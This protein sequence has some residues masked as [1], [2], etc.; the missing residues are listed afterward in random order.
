[1]STDWLG[2]FDVSLDEIRWVVNRACR[3]GWRQYAD[4][5]FGEVLLK[6][7]RKHGADPECFKTKEDLL[8][9][10]YV[11][12]RNE[13][14]HM[15]REAGRLKFGDPRLLSEKGGEPKE[16]QA[17][18]TSEEFLAALGDAE[19]EVREVFRLHLEGK[20]GI[21]IAEM[22]GISSSTVSRRLERAIAL[23]RRRF[24]GEQ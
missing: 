22:L 15:F 17:P 10:A 21:E 23:V 2:K 6:L 19:P 8:G 4:D 12:A 11:V 24:R 20:K 14:K 16:E 5:I 13:L 1:M 18:P 9:Y 3:R 7:H